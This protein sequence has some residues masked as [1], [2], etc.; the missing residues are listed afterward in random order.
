[1]GMPIK[2]VISRFRINY[3]EED[4]P[5]RFFDELGNVI[6]TDEEISY[7]AKNCFASD[8]RDIVI[9]DEFYPEDVSVR[10][11]RENEDA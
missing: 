1:M 7:W 11:E 10:I 6:A 4:F 3:R 9:Q 8:I 5:S 2:V